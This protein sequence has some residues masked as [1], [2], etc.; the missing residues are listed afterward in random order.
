MATMMFW[1]AV[2][3]A[4]LAAVLGALAGLAAWWVA[5]R[6]G[7]PG[8]RG[9]RAAAGA[10]GAAPP[11]APPALP[12]YAREIS[13]AGLGVLG[14][15]EVDVYLLEAPIAGASPAEL[16]EQARA[17]AATVPGG[18]SVEPPKLNL[19]MHAGLGIVGRLEGGGVVYRS[20]N[21]EARSGM[22]SALLPP[23]SELRRAAKTGEVA[24]SN[25]VMVV[26]LLPTGPYGWHGPG[27]REEN[28]Y[29]EQE[30]KVF[31]SVPV[32]TFDAFLRWAR[33][34]PRMFPLYR[35]CRLVLSPA[36]KR[37][38]RASG[39]GGAPPRVLLEA[40]TC[41]SFALR[42]FTHLAAL[43]SKPLREKNG[44]VLMVRTNV[45]TLYT[46]EEAITPCTRR[47]LKKWARQ[48]L[49]GFQVAKG[50]HCTAESEKKAAEEAADGR[51][52]TW[53]SRRLHDMHRGASH[54]GQLVRLRGF[55]VGMGGRMILSGAEDN[56]VSY[57]SLID[58]ER[59]APPAYDA[60][61]AVGA[62]SDRPGRQRG[63]AGLRSL[64]NLGTTRMS[65]K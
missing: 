31:S 13:A 28:L 2:L 51:G 26:E 62:L 65:E 22:T 11:E 25:A 3:G 38:A 32:P 43:G 16:G 60:L 57:L 42:A 15:T 9:P 36:E 48:A 24:W 12:D 8:A 49:G 29:W 35:G 41:G 53:L 47:E 5:A 27:H 59:M 6:A 7:R 50:L 58:T 39:E 52:R 54:A 1:H 14:A 19:M 64:A 23:L 34:Y 56:S 63:L 44:S 18:A 10:A 30:T 55:V 17:L 37:D 21:M 33:E 4:V 45:A 61:P 46:Q 20:Y 40:N